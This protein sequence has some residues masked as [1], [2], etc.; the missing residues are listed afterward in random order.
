MVATLALLT[1]L[2]APTSA[3]AAQTTQAPCETF[4]RESTA[5]PALVRAWF[6][7]STDQRVLVCPQPGAAPGASPPLYFGESAVTRHGNVCSYLNHG[8]AVEGSGAAR[9]LRRI[10]RSEAVAM[11]LADGEECPLPHAAVPDVYVMTYDVSRKAF[12]AIMELWLGFTSPGPAGTAQQELPVCCHLSARSA[13]APEGA[14]S[15]ASLKRLRAA[16]EDGRLKANALTRIV[17]MPG[18]ALRRRYALFVKDPDRVKDR[19]AG[20][21]GLYVIYVQKRLRAPY[22]VSDVGESN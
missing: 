14:A 13:S 21:P 5:A 3:A 8:L 2:F 18:S 6:A 16:A 20:Q 22:E 15:T 12:A 9:R 19:P 1:L 11:A 17:R 7:Q 10:E 4:T